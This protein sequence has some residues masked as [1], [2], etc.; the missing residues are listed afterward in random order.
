MLCC[1]ICI[2]DG[3]F[4]SSGP[5]RGPLYPLKSGVSRGPSGLS[6]GSGPLRHPVIRPLHVLLAAEGVR[7]NQSN[8]PPRY[9]PAIFG[10][11][12]NIS[13]KLLWA[14]YFKVGKR[15]WP[16]LFDC[17]SAYGLLWWGST[18]GYPSDSLASCVVVMCIQNWRT[19]RPALWRRTKK[20]P[21]SSVLC[22][23]ELQI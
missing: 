11:R 4:I 20:L 6:G 3:W 15:L 12:S 22:Y 1:V 9:G 21:F 5:F 18:V 17:G 7:S 2:D 16:L 14:R 23:I 13:S 19:A 10:I 8:P